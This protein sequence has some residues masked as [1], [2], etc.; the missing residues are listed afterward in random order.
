MN[1]AALLSVP[2]IVRWIEVSGAL[3]DSVQRSTPRI[4]YVSADEAASCANRAFRRAGRNVASAQLLYRA[5][6]LN[7][8]QPEALL[9]LSD[10]FRTGLREEAGDRLV[11]A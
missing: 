3:L 11:Y 4:R 8:R 9:V 6:E 10:F 1:A 2:F 7:S 5:L